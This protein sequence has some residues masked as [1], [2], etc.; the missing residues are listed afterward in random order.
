MTQVD[1]TIGVS[2]QK[3]VPGLRIPCRDSK[4]GNPGFF[5]LSPPTF[6]PYN[7]AGCGCLL[8]AAIVL[9]SGLQPLGSSGTD[10]EK[11]CGGFTDAS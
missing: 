10:G 3:D 9:V 11:Y 7:R 8:V 4:S 1:A 5:G 2:I 6:F